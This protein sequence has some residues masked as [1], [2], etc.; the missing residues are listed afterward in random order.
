MENHLANIGLIK[1]M[2]INGSAIKPDL[3]MPMIATHDIGDYAA[4]RLTRLDFSGSS[5]KELLG[6]RDLTMTEVTRVLGQAIGRPDLPYVQFSYEDAEK[7]MVQAGL[8]PDVARQY[9]A[10]GR[11]FNEGR[12][13]PRERRDATNT[14]PTAIEAFARE[15]A[16]LFRRA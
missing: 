8:S 12:I 3:S 13:R 16:E 11:G 6:A 7:A 15:F 2:G 9:I 5:A 10:M 4:E 1:G 14:T